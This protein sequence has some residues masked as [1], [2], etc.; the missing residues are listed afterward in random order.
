MEKRGNLFSNHAGGKKKEH[1]GQKEANI[2]KQ[3][4][5]FLARAE[6]A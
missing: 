1:R 6:T 3:H 2:N 5:H 4:I